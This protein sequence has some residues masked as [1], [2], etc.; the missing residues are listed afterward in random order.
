MK[1]ILKKKAERR[2]LKGY[3][4]VFSNEI[5]RVDD[6]S[7]D[8]P[9]AELYDYRGRFLGKGFYNKHSLIAFRLLTTIQSQKIDRDFFAEKIKA[10]FDFRSKYSRNKSAFRTVYGESD[11]LPGLVI[12]KYNDFFSIQVFSKGMEHYIDIITDI[13][14][15]E[16]KAE[17]VV[18]KNNFPYRK[19]EGLDLYEKIAFPDTADQLSTIVELDGLKYNIDLLKGQKSGHYLDQV[20]NRLK[21][22]RFV[23]IDSNVLDLFCNDGGFAMNAA[24][25]G[26]NSV[27]AVD[28]SEVA[29][30]QAQQNIKLNNLEEKI[31]FQVSDVFDYLNLQVKN[32]KKYDLIIL[33]PPALAKSRKDFKNAINAYIRLN[34]K[35]M[36][37]IAQRG[38]LFS[39]SCSGVISE[40]SFREI[41]VKSAL[42]AKRKVRVIDY[43][44]CSLDHPFLPDMQETIYLKS[45]LIQV[46]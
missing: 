38:F 45:Y 27:T 9:I 1:I 33:D 26:A 14:V 41:I 34:S 36:M 20:D 24:L 25:A 31:S 40:S 37:L 32:K 13:L 22:R 3:Q 29:I 8:E 5:D 21:I 28:I 23:S 17:A 18:L 35:A 10:A 2:F 15:N 12:D 11:F 19:L 7:Q 39:F 43:S 6:Y 42:I 16:L 30:S 46:I 44:I 4:W